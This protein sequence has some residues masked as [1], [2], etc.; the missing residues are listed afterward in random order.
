MNCFVDKNE[1]DEENCPSNQTRKVNRTASAC[2]AC[3]H[4]GVCMYVNS[5]SY[6]RGVCGTTMIS[7]SCIF[8]LTTILYFD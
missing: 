2:L 3:M 6:A 4:V 7:M 8:S 1:T 5:E